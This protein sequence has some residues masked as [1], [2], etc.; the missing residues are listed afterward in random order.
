[1][2]TEIVYKGYDNVI[3]LL[4]KKNGVA[5][6]LSGVTKMELLLGDVMISSD[7]QD[8]D[9]IRWAKDGY[10]T[11]E[12]RLYLGPENIELD[13]YEASL[14]VFDEFYVDGLVWGKVKIYVRDR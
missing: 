9:P 14:T 6:D 1:M 11:G 7:N 5:Q 13:D 2:I 4:L 8:S 3:N 10:S 12:V